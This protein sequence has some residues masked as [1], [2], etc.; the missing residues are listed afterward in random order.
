V[1]DGAAGL[2]VCLVEVVAVAFV[3]SSLITGDGGI[4]PAE[5]PSPTAA[6]TGGGWVGIGES[7]RSTIPSA[8]HTARN[9]LRVESIVTS[10]GDSCVGVTTCWL[11][12]YASVW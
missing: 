3:V 10:I 6:S 7:V 9:S 5:A 12:L 1:R 11:S 2:A 4:I 8:R